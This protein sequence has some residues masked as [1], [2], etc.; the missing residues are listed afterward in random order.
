MNFTTSLNINQNNTNLWRFELWKFMETLLENNDISKM[1]S[2]I[3]CISLLKTT[4]Q[5]ISKDPSLI[6]KYEEIP[7]VLVVL[8]E[9]KRT[10]GFY[11]FP[12]NASKEL[13]EIE[14]K[15]K[16][17]LL[18]VESGDSDA[19]LLLF[20]LMEEQHKIHLQETEKELYINQEE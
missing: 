20:D 5:K 6:D 15:I 19:Q 7:E 2:Y 18:L 11:T 8:E 1:I 10:N 16:N 3:R 12:K 9:I 14:E 17:L 13:L 4:E